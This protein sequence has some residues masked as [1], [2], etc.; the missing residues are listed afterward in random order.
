MPDVADMTPEGPH[1]TEGD[2]DREEEET[3]P[4][5]SQKP[6]DSDGAVQKRSNEDHDS[7]SQ[8]RSLLN[9]QLTTYRH[10][11]LKRKLPVDSQLL[12]CAREG[13]A[14]KRQM[15][16]EMTKMDRVVID[17]MA[18]LSQ[19]MMS[20]MTSTVADAFASIRTMLLPQ[21]Q[22]PSSFYPNRVPFGAGPAPFPGPMHPPIHPL[23]TTVHS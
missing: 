1:D 12:E 4:P 20:Q 5:M 9:Q 15:V 7:S 17:N 2:I 10:Q 18:Q 11:K 22:G 21:A 8:R 6:P 16:E 19:N 14:V 23:C 3:D 13:L